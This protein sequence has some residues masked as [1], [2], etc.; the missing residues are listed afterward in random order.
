MTFSI[1]AQSVTKLNIYSHLNQKKSTK[2]L[3]NWD[4][5]AFL[6]EQI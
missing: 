4:I 3:T 5:R 2:L 6:N 1:A